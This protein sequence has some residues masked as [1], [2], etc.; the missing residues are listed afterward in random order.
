ML[1]ATLWE[2]LQ[3][4]QISADMVSYCLVFSLS[5]NGVFGGTSRG[6]CEVWNNNWICVLCLFVGSVR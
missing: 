6:F 4:K 2:G 5:K 1:K 3:H